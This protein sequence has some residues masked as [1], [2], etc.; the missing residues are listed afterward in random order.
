MVYSVSTFNDLD[1]HC[2]LIRRGLIE[3]LLLW[4]RCWVEMTKES[5]RN[6]RAGIVSFKLCIRP[7]AP[8][9]GYA[10]SSGEACIFG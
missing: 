5:L 10:Q 7:A 2:A 6:W 8:L 1:N 9:W 4:L 3:R